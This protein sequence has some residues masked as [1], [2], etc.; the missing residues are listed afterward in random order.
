M[1][2]AF[3]SGIQ[4]TVFIP[5]QILSIHHSKPKDF[6][7][8]PLPAGANATTHKYTFSERK[9]LS[10]CPKYRREEVPFDG[11]FWSKSALSFVD[12]PGKGTFESPPTVLSPLSQ[13]AGNQNTNRGYSCFWHKMYYQMELPLLYTQSKR[14]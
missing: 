8:L 6:H 10:T 3:Q 4:R 9:T 12:A 2:L 5:G 14:R 7:I 1:S 13:Q 11:T